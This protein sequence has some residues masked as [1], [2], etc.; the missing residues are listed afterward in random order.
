MTA[1]YAMDN[2]AGKSLAITAQTLYLVNLM[3]A[4]GLAFV[5]LLLLYWFKRG[6]AD[7]LAMNHL[8]QTVGVS[9]AGAGLILVVCTV[10]LLLGGLDSGYTWMVVILYFTFIHSSL[11]L[12][13]V[14]GLVK[15]MAGQHYVFPLIGRPF[16]S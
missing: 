4:P 14:M 2:E 7:A 16:R 12:M 6:Q 13:G 1:V 9:I 5:L 15:A 11:I 3:L 10:F 8:S